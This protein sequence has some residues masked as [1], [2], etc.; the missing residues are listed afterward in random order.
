M[1]IFRP[2]LFLVVQ[3]EDKRPTVFAAAPGCHIL[4]RNRFREIGW[5]GHRLQRFA[6]GE[7]D[8]YGPRRRRTR[9]EE[10]A[11]GRGPGVRHHL[12]GG[13]RRRHVHRPLGMT[14][15]HAGL[16][17]GLQCAPVHHLRR[18]IRGESQKRHRAVSRLDYRGKEVG[19]GRPR[20]ADHGHRL[21]CGARHT[22]GKEGS[23][24]VRPGG[25][26]S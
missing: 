4:F 6:E 22:Q 18:S 3:A 9:A 26:T 21:T 10:G 25:P 2:W 23:P 24:N 20:R 8:V 7:I 17:D 13:F 11:A 1:Y 16:V 5:D 14:S 15:V 19:A 12:R